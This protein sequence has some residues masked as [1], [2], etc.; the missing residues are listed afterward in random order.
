MHEP[1]TAAEYKAIAAGLGL[2]TNAFIDGSFRPANSGKTFET[3]NPAT[4]ELL[5]N[6]AACDVSDVDYAVLK[7]REAF[8]DGRWRHRGF[9]L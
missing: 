6:I 4:G 8:E 3:I 1:L 2:P 5:A 9:L 7:A